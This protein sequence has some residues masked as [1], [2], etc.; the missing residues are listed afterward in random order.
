MIHFLLLVNCIV[1]IELFY[2]FN[3]FLHTSLCIKIFNK[4]LKIILSKKISD[5]W[6]EIMVPFYALQ[7]LKKSFKILFYFLTIFIF[8][9]VTNK[10]ND[11][12]FDFI[13]SLSGTVEIVLFSFTYIYLRK[14]FKK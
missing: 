4:V 9:L 13:I 8:F 6:K 14:I 3:F 12:L 10:I 5:H 1:S 7:I 11:K 2:K